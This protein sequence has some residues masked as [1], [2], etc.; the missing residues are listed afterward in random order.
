MQMGGQAIFLANIKGGVGKSTL[1]A[2]LIDYFKSAFSDLK[3][4]AC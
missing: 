2:F 1:T 4:S 3:K